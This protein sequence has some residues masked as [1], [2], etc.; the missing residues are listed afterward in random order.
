MVLKASDFQ[1]SFY[2][3][4]LQNTTNMPFSIFNSCQNQFFILCIFLFVLKLAV[5]NRF[6]AFGECLTSSVA[7]ITLKKVCKGKGGRKRGLPVSPSCE[8]NRRE[9]ENVFSLHITML[10]YLLPFLITFQ[11]YLWFL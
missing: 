8:I 7:S 11:I 1:K 6:T 5:I 10:Q 9:L 3:I 2:C 4:C